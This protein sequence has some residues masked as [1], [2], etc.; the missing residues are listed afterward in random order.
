[1]PQL[2]AYDIDTGRVYLAPDVLP[3][4][5]NMFAWYV[6]KRNQYILMLF[7]Q[8]ADISITSSYLSF[9]ATYNDITYEGTDENQDTFFSKEGITAG[10]I[11]N[12]TGAGESDNNIK[13]KVL[14]VIAGTAIGTTEHLGETDFSGGGALWSVDAGD[15]GLGVGEAEYD[16]SANQTSVLT[17][18]NGDLNNALDYDTYYRLAYTVTVDT[19]PD[20]DFEMFLAANEVAAIKTVLPHTAGDHVVEFYSG[21]NADIE[22]FN[23]YAVSGDDTEG[24]FQITNISIVTAGTGEKLKVD[25]D[26]TTEA[27]GN[28]VTIAQ[29]PATLMFVYDILGKRFTKFEGMNVIRAAVMAGGDQLHNL[30]LFLTGNSTITMYPDDDD[31]EY[32]DEDAYIE[33]E[34]DVYQMDLKAVAINHESSSDSEV[35]LSIEDELNDTLRTTS[36]TIES[37][38]NNLI[39]VSM[40]RGSR[41][42][43]LT[44]LFK[45]FDKVKYYILNYINRNTRRD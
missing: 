30:N 3:P 34:L 14:A 22:D 38:D 25:Q 9:R 42:N 21:P 12:I 15:W 20:G 18:A 39:P 24:T 4:R 35:E 36:K 26:L 16:W 8:D 43:K 6:P 19:A 37:T 45:D 28:S 10:M 41:G 7:D 23:I 11:F 1:M 44:I 13:V 32:T 29:D 5:Y 40:P 17:Q 2:Q 27:E 31:G 33:K